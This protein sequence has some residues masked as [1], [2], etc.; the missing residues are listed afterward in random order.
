MSSNSIPSN[1]VS[2]IPIHT[3]AR[4]QALKSH[5]FCRPANAPTERVKTSRQRWEKISEREEKKVCA[6]CRQRY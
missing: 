3:P 4:A 1:I 5:E 6:C 2:S